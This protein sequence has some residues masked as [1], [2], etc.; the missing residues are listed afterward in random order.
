MRNSGIARWRYVDQD[1]LTKRIKK[2]PLGADREDPVYG[3]LPGPSWMQRA[4][5][6]TS[7]NPAP[8]QALNDGFDEIEAENLE[9]DEQL[10]AVREALE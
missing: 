1:L 6:A 10:K 7:Q 2:L 8:Q 5:D 3:D 4:A 9:A